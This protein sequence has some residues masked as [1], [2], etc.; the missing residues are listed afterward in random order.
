MLFRRSAVL[1]L[2]L[3][4]GLLA[5]PG[6][7]SA[8]TKAKI[9]AQEL[10]G[11]GRL[12]V[13]LD[14][15]ARAQARS[16]N[17][18]LV[19]NFDDQ[20]GVDLEKL[21]TQA[22]SYVA[23]ARRDP[24]GKTLRFALTQP[25]RVNLMEAGEQIFIDLLPESWRG[26]PPSLPQDVVENLARRAREAEE[27]LRRNQRERER[28]EVR[29]L[30]ARVG[31]GPTF[32]RLILE[33]GATVPIEL[34]RKGDQLTITFEAP[35]TLDL[36]KLKPQL[37][38]SVLAVESEL[39]AGSL[40]VSVAVAAGTEMRAFR[41]DDTVIVDFPRADR[42]G[43][44][45]VEGAEAALAAAARAAEAQPQAEGGNAPAASAGPAGAS[46]SAVAPA[47][48][49]PAP[50]PVV[51]MSDAALVR[52][53]IA[54]SGDG[55][56]ISLPFRD[57]TPG[58]AF[59]RGDTL[60]LVYDTAEALEPARIEPAAQ[61]DVKRVDV[62]RVG[63]AAVLRVQLAAP[64]PVAMSLEGRT[65][66]TTVGDIGVAPTEPL[67]IRRAVSAEGRTILATR[68][69]DAGQVFWLEDPESGERLGVVTAKGRPYGLPKVQQFVEVVALQT[70]YGLVVSPR[71][72]DIVVRVGL[73]EVVVARDRGLTITL[74]MNDGRGE[75]GTRKATELLLDTQTWRT[76]RNG[77]VHARGAELQRAAADATKRDRTEARLRLARFLIAN[78]FYPDAG[79]VLGVLAKEDEGA[80]ATKSVL[81]TR[82]MAAVMGHDFATAMKHLAA[83]SLALEPETTV[84]RAVLDAKSGR[85]TPA[86]AGLRQSGEVIDRYP[87]ELQA[88]LR[89]IAAEAA[90]EAGET[91]Y[92]TQQIDLVEQLDGTERD[93]HKLALLR[94]GI[95]EKLGRVEEARAHYDFA[96]R[97]PKRP[98]E[99]AARLAR[100]MLDLAEAGGSPPAG[101]A[102]TA[103]IAELETVGVIWRAGLVEVKALA[104]LGRLYAADMRWREAFAT[105]RRATEIQPDSDITRSLHD[106]MAQSFEK[107]FLDGKADE[108]PR[109]EAL[110]LYYDF[111][112]LTPISR[113]GDEMIRRL[114][115]KLAS[116]DLLDQAAELLQHQVDNRLGG[117]A[118][119]TVASRLA[120]I[121]LIN[122]KPV[123]A[124]QVLRA[125][126]SVSLPADVRR[127]RSL[128]EAR[129]LSELSR[130]DLAIEIL[131]AIDGPDASRLRA[132]VL[133]RGK[134]WREAGEAFERTL[135]DRW[136]GPDPLTDLERADAMRA[137]VSYVLADDRLSLD[138]LR[139]KFAQKMA[140]SADARAF[141]LVTSD[142]AV[143]QRD[144][145]DLAR[146]VV[147]GDTLADFLDD[148]R[149]RYPE[150]AGQ[151]RTSA[152]NAGGQPPA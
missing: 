120:V 43:A 115:D 84:W 9:V 145:R 101:D 90:V 25:Y 150:A 14:K 91:A 54:R 47:A 132:D 136:Q 15:A 38:P 73:D 126:R 36:A 151:P 3:A 105:A 92:A 138:R 149:K 41:E 117:I 93:A 39:V 59:L 55:L 52:P 134:R 94:G 6:A 56:R 130:T 140:D 45:P 85:L 10:N 19:V 99:A 17:S 61:A 50:R 30:A 42:A 27:L 107:L 68:L 79:A 129:A 51:A 82:A 49:G 44:L 1:P 86:L 113:R 29:E 81:L 95:A 11:Y 116:L 109:V 77:D 12:I 139:G 37:P 87:D 122:R 4:L 28:R 64:Q 133:W 121:Y 20:I 60:W 5:A 142:S 8:E 141:T 80:A 152:L 7:P 67:S 112:N 127:G 48:S 62:D 26:L 35:L 125:T 119:A 128:L 16:S 114:A 24:D 13:N 65:W 148:Y 40:K 147:S 58:A 110:G 100:V 144:F 53:V 34:D 124:L 89:E 135:G 74:G 72:D 63:G 76:D 137:G 131:A 18:I 102:R 97:S 33:T 143:R 46:P 22:P 96:A 104:L 123:E 32:H 146:S 71:A 21:P 78:G 83:P 118:R 57:V 75:D 106:E 108:L 111:R 103:A 31:T 88:R 23:V 69:P 2:A 70:A 98:V 66:T